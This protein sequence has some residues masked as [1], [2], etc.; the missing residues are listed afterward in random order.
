VTTYLLVKAADRAHRR[1]LDLDDFAMAADV[2]PQ[3][4]QR[5]VSLG[6]LE[7]IRDS[8]GTAWFSPADLAT[9][10]R[11][12]RLRAGFGIN[13][14]AIGLVLDLLERVG[15][16]EAALRESRRPNPLHPRE[17]TLS[18]DQDGRRQTWI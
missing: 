18:A 1:R 16:L 3:L 13:Y 2:H 11:I 9:I 10:A 6:L 14:A 8:A 17:D 4:V 15:R 7:P 12:Q 5:L